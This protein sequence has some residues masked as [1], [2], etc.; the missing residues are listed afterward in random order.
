MSGLQYP[1]PP[2]EFP[3]GVA[4]T[5]PVLADFQP[6]PA[7][8]VASL[9]ESLPRLQ[10]YFC[11]NYRTVVE[12]CA[13]AF[14]SSVSDI[15]SRSRS[16]HVCRPRHSSYLLFRH[17]SGASYPH[18]ADISGRSNHSSIHFAIKRLLPRTD[19]DLISR[20]AL[21]DAHLRTFL[22]NDYLTRHPPK[23]TP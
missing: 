9:I 13:L 22:Y 17:H 16:P 11:S 23:D 6:P 15:F 14:N 18:I 8:T 20:I 5:I 4:N 7:S 10:P 3:H 1:P 12:A 21:A 19:S 2:D